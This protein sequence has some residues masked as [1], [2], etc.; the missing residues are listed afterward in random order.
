MAVLKLVL[1]CV[2]TLVPL[3]LLKKYAAEQAILLSG[4]VFILMAYH[5]LSY[6]APVLDK[7]EEL[8]VRAGIES[9]Y[10]AILLKTVAASLVSHLCADLCRDGGSQALAS[11]V[12]IAGTVASLLISMPLLE[13]VIELLLVFFG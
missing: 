13:A 6:A 2:I 10:F 5:C 11:L 3:V 7:L 1:I 12:E 4:A 9:M 8:F